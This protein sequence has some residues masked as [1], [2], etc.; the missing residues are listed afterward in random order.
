M[1]TLAAYTFEQRQACPRETRVAVHTIERKRPK[2]LPVL[3]TVLEGERLAA[4]ARTSGGDAAGSTTGAEPESRAVAAGAVV[5]FVPKAPDE[6]GSRVPN[7]Q[8]GVYTWL[9]HRSSF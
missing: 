4:L 3:G 1:D 9:G 6:V 5:A 8:P 7:L 2:F